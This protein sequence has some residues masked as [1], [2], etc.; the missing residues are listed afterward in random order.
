MIKALLYQKKGL[1]SFGH[2]K[3]IPTPHSTTQHYK[4]NRYIHV[5]LQYSI[6]IHTL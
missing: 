4:T 5:L 1:K 3:N 2:K 6:F